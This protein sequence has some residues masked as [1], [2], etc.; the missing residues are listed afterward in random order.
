MSKVTFGVAW[1]PISHMCVRVNDL[2]R[3][4]ASRK[5]VISV[6]KKLDA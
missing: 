5:S 6:F 3:C 4:M 2:W 1:R